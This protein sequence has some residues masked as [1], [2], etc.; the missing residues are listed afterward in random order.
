MT[1]TVGLHAKT[2]ILIH[3]LILICVIAQDGHWK[4]NHKYTGIHTSVA[5]DCF[6]SLEIKF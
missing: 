1:A 6:M 2:S 4:N 5:E 3:V